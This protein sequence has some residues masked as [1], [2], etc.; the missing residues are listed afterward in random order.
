VLWIVDLGLTC[1]LIYG[2]Y[3]A[4]IFACCTHNMGDLG[5]ICGYDDLGGSGN[6]F[7]DEMGY[8]GRKDTNKVCCEIGECAELDGIVDYNATATEYTCDGVAFGQDFGE[9]MCNE[10]LLEDISFYNY[11]W[12]NAVLIIKCVGLIFMLL[13][14]VRSCVKKI[15]S[16]KEEAEQ[17]ESC[18]DCKKW[19]KQC[20]AT[21]IVLLLKA[22]FL[23]FGTFATFAAVYYMQ[24][25]GQVWTSHCSALPSSLRSQ[26]ED[27]QDVCNDGGNYYAVAFD[28]LE[29]GGP[30]YVD[31]IS[32]VL[33]STLWVVRIAVMR[34][35]IKNPVGR[36]VLAP[37]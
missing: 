28:S 9:T 19:G 36:G 4:N 30:Y 3:E 13:L 18:C 24:L 32:N 37:V 17:S 33:H 6:I 29:L 31:I 22:V 25:T 8:C 35:I 11:F 5:D 15:E 10:D 21:S 34:Y 23:V 2:L 16:D 20:C 1:Y 14:E 7:V 26:C 12:L 27:T